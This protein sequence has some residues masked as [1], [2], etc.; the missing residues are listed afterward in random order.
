MPES[1]FLPFGVSRWCARSREMG[2][3]SCDEDVSCKLQEAD[4][5]LATNPQPATCNL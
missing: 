5:W 2:F 1:F 4:Y 3:D